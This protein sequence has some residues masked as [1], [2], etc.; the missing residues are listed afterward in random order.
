MADTFAVAG[1]AG[2]VASMDGFL[3]VHHM[4]EIL[5][6]AWPAILPAHRTCWT[7]Q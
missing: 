1:I 5:A 6:Y 3:E 4:P 2:G 7:S